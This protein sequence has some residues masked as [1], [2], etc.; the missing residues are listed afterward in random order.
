MTTTL[1][2]AERSDAD[3]A[4]VEDA[5]LSAALRVAARVRQ[6]YLRS[7]VARDRF[8]AA[9]EMRNHLVPL[10]ARAMAVAHAMGQRRS[11]LMAED[12]S[13][14]LDRFSEVMREVR[15]AG[16]GTDL[17]RL[18]RGYA[19]KL[20][21]SMRHMGA[22]V[23]AKTRAFI[24]SL[25]ADKV[26]KTKAL[27]ILSRKLGAL[28]AHVET[29]YRTEMSAAYHAG[30]WQEDQKNPK[31]WGYRYVQIDRPTKRDEH[32]PLHGTTLP[33]GALFW[34]RYWPPNGWN[35]VPKGTL[36]VTS[37]GQVPIERVAVGDEVLTHRGRFMPVVQL[38]RSP[39]SSEI[40]TV[41]REASSTRL[42]ANHR[43]LTQRG[44]VEAS[45]LHVGDD[46]L[47][48]VGVTLLD[49]PR[50]H[51]DDIRQTERRDY[52][53]VPSG[54]SL[55]S[56][57]ALDS[58]AQLRQIEV[59]PVLGGVLVEQ[60]SD[61]ELVE[62]LREALF[63]DG[64]RDSG[65]GMPSWF[66]S[67]HRR[68]SSSYFSLNFWTQR[69]RCG[70]KRERS[71]FRPARI[72]F[73]RDDLGV[74]SAT[75]NAGMVF[76]ELDEWTVR[77]SRRFRHVGERDS[78]LG[79]VDQHLLETS[80][81]TTL[82]TILG[83]ESERVRPVWLLSGHSIIVLVTRQKIQQIDI[84]P[85]NEEV[86]NLSVAEDESYFADGMAVHNCGCTVVTLYRK[87]KEKLPGKINGRVPPPDD[88]FRGVLLE[89]VEFSFD[90]NQPRDPGGEGGGQWVKEGYF[91][92]APISK[93]S[94]KEAKKW[95]KD[96]QSKYDSDKE[97][98]TVADAVTIYTQGS[99]NILSRE[100]SVAVGDDIDPE[101]YKDE[102]VVQF[103]PKKLGAC[104]SPLAEYKNYFK[105]QDVEN[106]E[107][108]TVR[109][110]GAAIHR[111]I[112]RSKSFDAPFYRGVILP[113]SQAR[114]RFKLPTVG[115]EIKLPGVTSFTANREIAEDFATGNAKGQRQRG[116]INP[117]ALALTF[118]VQSGGKGIKVGALSPWS[119]E[120]IISAGKFKIVEVKQ[121]KIAAKNTMIDHVHVVMK[122][123]ETYNP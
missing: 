18:Q 101:T 40:V 110:A 116:G 111:T 106:T 104:A 96:M 122:Q 76:H 52:G 29:I 109:E 112:H 49:N 5:G 123:T 37:R 7:F 65:V 77:N 120:E 115:D 60:P 1:E 13:V 118:E 58:D 63:D 23:D 26:P 121:G 15:D 100:S 39:G 19:K 53:R 11:V 45:G 28:D 35:C 12:E 36:V 22:N 114:S 48:V 66:G 107:V 16:V 9:A 42:T 20:Y 95:R 83:V 74:R 68:T 119:Q 85:F 102:M 46:V 113:P 99:Y 62:E 51:V 69:G 78:L 8:S 27:E 61:L 67:V 44:W 70:L 91:D 21:D 86:F 4:R 64:H 94:S 47:D 59:E 10:L 24:A 84:V 90:P 103:G 105:N 33:K 82:D 17:T 117:H 14:Q 89:P 3:V 50:R 72:Q 92:D 31:V 87:N 93:A 71:F 88:G 32:V 2:H 34:R 97:F 41:R 79:V 55:M 38:H 108:S 80:G 56:S 54:A 73:V 43:V 57:L 6:G 25:I 30:R 75:R 81:P 98:K